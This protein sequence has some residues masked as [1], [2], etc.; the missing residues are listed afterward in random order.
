MI[1]A[2]SSALGGIAQATRDV[3]Q[4]A[5]RTAGS[6]DPERLPSDMVSLH[7]DGVAVKANVAVIRAADEMIGSLLD[8]LG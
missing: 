3:A 6:P 5:Q 7:Q 2:V 4:V 8:S 1:D